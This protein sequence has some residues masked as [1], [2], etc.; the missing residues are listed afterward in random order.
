MIFFD[1]NGNIIEINK[2][3]FT[4]DFLYYKKIYDLKIHFTKNMIDSSCLNDNKNLNGDM[5]QKPY[6]NYIIEKNYV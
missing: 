2:N 5:K 3:D 4:N 6:S 1:I